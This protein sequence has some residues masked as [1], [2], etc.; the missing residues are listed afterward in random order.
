MEEK[1]TS[2]KCDM[3]YLCDVFE[4]LSLLNKQLQDKNC[5]LFSSKIITGFLGKVNLYA[6]NIGRRE[7]A[8]F[9]SLAAVS[10]ELKDDE[11]IVYVDHLKQLYNDMEVCFHDLLDMDIP[12]WVVDPF[13]VNAADVDVSLQEALIE[14][15]RDIAAK[16]T[17]SQEKHHF[18]IKILF[19]LLFFATLQSCIGDSFPLEKC[20]KEADYE[21]FLEI[22]RNGLKKTSQPRRVVIVGAGVSGLSA[23]YALTEAGHEVTILE[24]SECVGGRVQTYRNEREGWYAN[25]G[26][27]RLPE[28]H[29]I[30]REYVKK[31]G[32][33]LSEFIPSDDNAWILLNNIRK[34]VWEVNE[35]PSL[36]NY[37]V[38][39]SEE[40]KTAE[41]LYHDSLTTVKEEVMRTNCTYTLNKYDTF[42]TKQYLVKVANLSRGA[43]QM[44]GDI[45]N[46]DAG[47]YLSF[48]ESLRGEAIFSA[49]K[50]FDEIVGGFDQLPKAIYRTLPEMVYF[51]ARVVQIEQSADSVTVFYQTAAEPLL[52]VTADYVIVTSTARATRRIHFK[53]HLSPNKMDALRSIHYRSAA[54]VLLACTEKFWEADGIHG[55]KSIT[56]RPS[57]FIYYPNH[58]FSSGFGVILA[59]Y[60]QNDDSRFFLS[61]SHDDIIS[62][63]MDDLSAIH[64]LP[65]R[66][67]QALCRSSVI[68]QWSLDRYAMCGFASFTPYQF[69]D[70]SEELARTEGRIHF[71]GEHTSKLHG[72]LDTTIKT[73]L[74]AARDI[75]LAAGGQQSESK[76][77]GKEE[78]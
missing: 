16:L 32:L 15:Q 2:A 61:L 37:D 50:R 28:S 35:D 65:K 26:A 30:V 18:W 76:P 53:P 67:I 64:Q 20:F 42:S 69:V 51:D 70:Y 14:L 66:K 39:P 58:N 46:E 24:A 23:A 12:A 78:L 22:A 8:Q 9:S 25:L 63:I 48:I 10:D 73:G 40:G 34:R 52:K 54:K 33:Q 7:F 13:A 5:D 60:V 47:Y 68:K 4:K 71:A 6:T 62:I 49:I 55:G 77:S 29:K 27:M 19:S 57:R 41:Q 72:W 38:K 17:F 3:F 31:F 59:S 1:I 44:I 56:D 36:L 74:R 45:L 75:N 11:I 43:V 21:E